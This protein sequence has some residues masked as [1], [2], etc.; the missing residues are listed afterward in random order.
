MRRVHR[1]GICKIKIVRLQGCSILGVRH[2]A[3]TLQIYNKEER[4]KGG[5]YIGALS[6]IW[7]LVRLHIWQMLQS[8][9]MTV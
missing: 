8:K 2:R 1:T 6:R 4:R 5:Y 7:L 9:K 3:A